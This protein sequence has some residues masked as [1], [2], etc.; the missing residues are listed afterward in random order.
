M[1]EID[2]SQVDAF[3]DR[4][5][6]RFGEIKFG[7]ADIMEEVA[8]QFLDEVVAELMTDDSYY[9]GVLANSFGKGSKG[10]VWKVSDGGLTLEVGTNVKYADWVNTGHPQ[11]PGR[12][13]PG[14]WTG[15]DRFHYDPGS[16]EGMVLKASWVE[17]THYF[18][19]VLFKCSNNL[20][21]KI[22]QR[23]A[24]WARQLLG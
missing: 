23:F 22:K 17:G 15:D 14:Y 7:L 9:S 24:L 5:K 6:R 11:T 3:A 8:L 21:A 19:R 1:I 16:D 18:D 20:T 10:N 4:L 2:S 13:V 12:F